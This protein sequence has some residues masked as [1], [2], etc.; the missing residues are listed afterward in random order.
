MYANNK[1]ILIP[2]KKS[3]KQPLTALDKLNNKF[4]KLISK[5]RIAVENIYKGYPK[6]LE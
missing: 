4:I 2:K 6:D 1:N 3:K 5:E